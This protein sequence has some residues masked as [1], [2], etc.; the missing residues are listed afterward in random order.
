[1]IHAAVSKASVQAL[2]STPRIIQQGGT[3]SANR[4]KDPVLSRLSLSFSAIQA[5]STN[6]V[7]NGYLQSRQARSPHVQALIDSLAEHLVINP[8]S[9]QTSVTD[10]AKA[11][12]ALQKEILLSPP[13]AMKRMPDTSTPPILLSLCGQGPSPVVKAL[14][15]SSNFINAAWRENVLKPVSDI[16]T[17]HTGSSLRLNQLQV[18]FPMIRNS[19]ANPTVS[20]QARLAVAEEHVTE[21]KTEAQ[22]SLAFSLDKLTKDPT[23]EQSGVIEKLKTGSASLTEVR[24]TFNYVAS[25]PF[26]Q[27]FEARMEL[28]ER[29]EDAFR[30][31]LFSAVGNESNIGTEQATKRWANIQSKNT[32]LWI[33]TAAGLNAVVTA[34]T[35]VPLSPEATS[36]I[37]FAIKG[38]GSFT[39]NKHRQR[40]E[41]NQERTGFHMTPTDTESHDWLKF[42]IISAIIIAAREALK[43]NDEA[44]KTSD[45]TEGSNK[46]EGLSD[47]QKDSLV[48]LCYALLSITKGSHLFSRI[49]YMSA[50][51]EVA[52]HQDSIKESAYREAVKTKEAITKALEESP[53]PEKEAFMLDV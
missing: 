45:S 42:F 22:K 7:T 30:E 27:K 48:T 19:M 44:A 5:H 17:A 52:R 15:T 26:M 34:C 37:C 31:I 6:T 24:E 1:M 11:W 33:G 28:A 21:F 36:A 46:S 49:G 53:P 13:D 41:Q 38:L 25:S 39:T 4:V 20:P 3:R 9:R 32:G 14:N 16:S 40:T 51:S 18:R 12:V 10:R 23:P 50:S 8:T 29:R 2:D 47:K 43:A 35:G